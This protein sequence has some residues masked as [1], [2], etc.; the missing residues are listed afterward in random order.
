MEGAV[1]SLIMVGVFAFG[2]FAAN[3][4]DRYIDGSRRGA[5][6]DLSWNGN[7]GHTGGPE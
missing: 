6:H 5:H 1:L 3:R 7:A 4:M 2:F